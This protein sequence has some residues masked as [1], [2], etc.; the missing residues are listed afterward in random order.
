MPSL[1]RKGRRFSPRR[2]VVRL[3][4]RCVRPLA[5]GLLVAAAVSYFLDGTAGSARRER[6]ISMVTSIKP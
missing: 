4:F 2:F 3:V 5:P 1:R 6:A